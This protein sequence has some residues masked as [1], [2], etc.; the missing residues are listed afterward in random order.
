MGSIISINPDV[1]NAHYSNISTDSHYSQPAL[2]HTCSTVPDWINERDVFYA[3]DHLKCTST[4]PDNIPYW[5]LK[6][7]SPF[8]TEPLTFLFRKSICEASVPCLLYTSPS[9]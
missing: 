9:P 3:I 2:K 6:L 1:L 7:A 5:F 4:G 8:I